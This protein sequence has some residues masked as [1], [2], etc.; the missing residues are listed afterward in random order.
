MTE[1]T[2]QEGGMT[3]AEVAAWVTELRTAQGL[4]PRVDNATT[5]QHVADLMRAT[6]DR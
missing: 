6:A 1:D 3:A 5:Q 2:A 4:P